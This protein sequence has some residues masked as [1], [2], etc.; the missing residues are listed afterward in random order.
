MCMTELHYVAFSSVM[1]FCKTFF[2][3]STVRGAGCYVI[4]DAS[5]DYARSSLLM[6]V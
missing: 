2:K 1:I 6:G 4:P 3:C 5:S